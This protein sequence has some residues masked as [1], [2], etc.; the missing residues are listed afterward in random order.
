LAEI[1][2]FWMT[3]KMLDYRPQSVIL[4]HCF[5]GTYM[6]REERLLTMLI[7]MR[8]MLRQLLPDEFWQQPMLVKLAK[9][10]SGNSSL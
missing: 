9:L 4:P 10:T 3:Q 2:N 8:S 1:D 7:A 6:F 5:S